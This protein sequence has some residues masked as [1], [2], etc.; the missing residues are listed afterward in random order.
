MIRV[1]QV[2]SGAAPIPLAPLIDCVFLL[3]I[4]FLATGQ[5]ARE[6]FALDYALPMPGEVTAPQPWLAEVVVQV[7]ADGLAEIN[8]YA[9]SQKMLAQMLARHRASALTGQVEPRVRVVPDGAAPHQ[10]VVSALDACAA[11]G[12]SAVTLAL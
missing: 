1:P 8:G 11:A 3:L 2:A 6:E 5:L 9:A 7:R 12:I 4:Y 10:A